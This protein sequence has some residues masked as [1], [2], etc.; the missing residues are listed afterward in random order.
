[1]PPSPSPPHPFTVTPGIDPS[2]QGVAVMSQM[3]Q[4]FVNQAR[5]STRAF[6]SEQEL[7][8]VSCSAANAWRT[9]SSCRP[10]ALIYQFSPTY[11]GGAGHSF[12]QV[13][14]RV[15]AS[16]A[17]HPRFPGQTYIFDEALL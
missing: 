15:P 9:W 1:V 4:F 7:E 14:L 16:F 10:Q 8:S 12:E 2:A 13:F 5:L 6:S 17:S 11:T 3:S